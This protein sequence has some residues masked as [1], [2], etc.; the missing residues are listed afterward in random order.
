MS[1]F[2]HT[3][4]VL[5]TEHGSWSLM[6]TPFVIGAGVAVVFSQNGSALA[7]LLCLMAVLALFLAR[8]PLTLWL[9]V[10]RGKARRSDEG[11]ARSWSLLLIAVAALCGIGLMA[12]GRWPVL[13]LA[14]PAGAV[15]AITLGMAALLGQRQIITELVGVVG[16]AL[17]APAAY[18]AFAGDLSEIA[19][20]LW[21]LSALHNVIS[22]LYVRLRID[23]RHERASQAEALT[24]VAAHLIGLGVVVG[25]VLGGWLPVL[26]AL[27]MAALLA[28]A[29]VVA[30][31]KP[32]L[33]NVKRFGF[34]EM[35]LAL[36]YALL[37]IA[38]FVVER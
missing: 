13:W 34:T 27:P 37:V 17:S 15:L 21:A 18:V 1:L 12:L 9:R 30:W 20:W 29:V 14:I 23:Q 38:A 8:Q 5:P 16:L 7:L 6:L 32:P 25:F 19:W 28:R 26:V 36:A 24:V 22:V 3:K 4:L 35:G 10:R 31:R 33:E 11:P 2:R